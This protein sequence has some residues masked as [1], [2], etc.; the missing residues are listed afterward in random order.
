MSLNS[1]SAN[2]EESGMSARKLKGCLTPVGQQYRFPE[3][4]VITQ[5]EP[6]ASLH[7][8]S[9]TTRLISQG[10]MSPNSPLVTWEQSQLP[11]GNSKG[12]LTPFLQLERLPKILVTTGEE[13]WVYHLNSRWGPI[14]LS[15]TTELPL[16][17][18][19][20]AWL[21]WGNHS[22]SLRSPW[23]L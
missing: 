14:P 7:N 2:R 18:R 6:R 22:S 1:L 13:P 11:P 15:L 3:V 10:K 20:E 4:N 17:T 16:T 5:I 19:K 23:Q 9:K 12:G 21:P 8:L